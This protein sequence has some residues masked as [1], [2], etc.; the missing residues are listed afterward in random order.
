MFILQFE[1]NKFIVPRGFEGLLRAATARIGL[2]WTARGSEGPQ[3]ATMDCKGPQGAA[4][5]RKGL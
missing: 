4:R 5:G 2:Q 1:T 3:G